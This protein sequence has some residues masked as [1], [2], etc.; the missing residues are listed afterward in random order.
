MN[1]VFKNPGSVIPGRPNKDRQ[2]VKKAP[3]AGTG[4]TLVELLVVISIIALLIALLLPALAKAKDLANTVVCASN[5]RSIDLASMEYSQSYGDEPLPSTTVSLT[6]LNANRWIMWP[7]ELILSGIIPVQKINDNGSYAA[8]Y[9]LPANGIPTVF[10]DPGDM[11]SVAQNAVFG[12]QAYDY[13][14]FGVNGKKVAVPYITSYTINGEY[15]AKTNHDGNPNAPDPGVFQNGW[16]DWR[17]VSYPLMNGI[18]GFASVNP[19]RVSSFHDPAQDVFFFDGT[20]WANDNNVENGPVGRHE[21]PPSVSAGNQ[22]DLTVGYS[23]LAFLD[24]HVALYARSKLPQSD[25]PAPGGFSADGG[26][27]GQP[28]QM[29]QPPWFNMNYDV[30]AGN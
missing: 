13:Y 22:T 25:L 7:A 5:M 27:Y 29:V 8:N 12:I 14:A 4:F 10:F 17:Y 6:G 28:K 11:D 21:R 26:M 30:M 9:N 19:P 1:A 18:R 16:D 23:N 3:H 15:F 2:R 20:E 24:G